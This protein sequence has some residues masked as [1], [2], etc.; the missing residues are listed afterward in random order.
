MSLNQKIIELSN[1]TGIPATILS[2]NFLDY[3]DELLRSMSYKGRESQCRL[4]AY[5]Q[6]EKNVEKQPYHINYYHHIKK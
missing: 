4:L 2:M 6:L 1:E 5:K 3:E